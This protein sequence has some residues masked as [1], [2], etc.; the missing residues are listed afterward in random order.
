MFALYGFNSENIFWKTI[1]LPYKKC[2]TEKRT[3]VSKVFNLL[4]THVLTAF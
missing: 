3:Y 1:L 2:D 4:N